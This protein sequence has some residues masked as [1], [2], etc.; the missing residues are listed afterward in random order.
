M[1]PQWRF[2]MPLVTETRIE[3]GFQRQAAKMLGTLELAK[4]A[5]NL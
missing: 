5:K 4:C 1:M 3:F 2:S